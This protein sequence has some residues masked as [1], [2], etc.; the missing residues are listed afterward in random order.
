MPERG[1]REPLLWCYP[2]RRLEAEVPGMLGRAASR[3]SAGRAE[4]P[5]LHGHRERL[6]LTTSL[7]EAGPLRPADAYRMTVHSGKD[8]IPSTAPSHHEDA[9]G[10]T[11]RRS[12]PWPHEHASVPARRQPAAPREADPT[13]P[14]G[15]ARSRDRLSRPPRMMRPPRSGRMRPRRGLISGHP[16]QLE[17]VPPCGMIWRVEIL[18][19]RGAPVVGAIPLAVRQG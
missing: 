10:A 1:R 16:L 12:S 7:V 2:V 19:P 5:S 14:A 3:T 11:G 17:R 9:R 4:L 18:G 6:E 15:P 8:P 13:W